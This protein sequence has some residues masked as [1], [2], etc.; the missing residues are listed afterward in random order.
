[1]TKKTL[2]EVK[3]LKVHFESETG[4]VRA[5]DG[6]DFEL[7]EGET[8]G[9]VGESGSGKSMTALSIMKLIPKAGKASGKISFFSN[10]NLKTDILNSKNNEIEIIRGNEIGMI[11]QEPMTSLNPVFKCGNQ[12]LETV[13]LHQKVSK[14]E[15]RKKVFDLFEKVKLP[16]ANRIFES[17][18][19]QLS[20]GQKQRVMIAMA[21]AGNPK[22]LI[23]DEPT[24]ALDVTVQ[25]SVLELINELKN[26]LKMSVIFISHDL[27]VI[28]EIADRILVMFKGKIMESGRAVDIFKKS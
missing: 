11:F 24:T 13:E 28:A 2:L 17:Y 27:G 26:E 9:I 3:D 22:I 18:P 6:I 8:I 19:H 23:A 21:L 5:V 16:D 14:E 12:V 10:D 1:M 7:K 25:K 4:L 20:G 15:A